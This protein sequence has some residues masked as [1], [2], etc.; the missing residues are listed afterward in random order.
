VDLSQKELQR[1][2]VIENAVQG[3]IR[4]GEAAELLELSPRQITR[5]KRDSLGG[6]A[7]WV[8]HGNR[9]KTPSNRLSETLRQQVVDL[10]AGRY[11][12]FNDTHLWEKLS[13]V[14]GL[15]LSRQSLQRI[16]RKAGRES[17]QKRRPPKYRSRRERRAQEG[18]MLQTDGS[19]HDW[20]EQRGPV[21]T[22]LGF[23]D[24][25][26][27]KVPNARF[28]LEGENTAGYL[29]LTRQVAE[30]KGVPLS[31]YRDQHGTFQRNDEHW[32]IQEQLAGS[33]AP[34]QLG[35]CWE[36]LGITS[37]PARSPQAKGR[38]ERLWRTFQD[39]LCSELRLAG[40]CTLEQA[41]A[42]LERFLP[43]FNLGFP[44]QPAQA[45]VAYRKLDRRLD[46]DYI[47]SFRYERVVN[48]DHTIV[49]GDGLRVQLPPLPGH[50]GY[51]G[52]K[53]EVC[54]LPNGDVKVY[55]DRRLLYAEAGGPDSPPVRSRDMRRV[56][57]PLKKKPLK[58]YAFAGRLAI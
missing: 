9:G 32:S 38:V 13:R 14:E 52:K 37:I 23:I 4:V 50:K 56:T 22:L 34:T 5:L 35:R 10:A 29:R 39:R 20:L 30:Q 26:T 57:G 51:A 17:P 12:G 45:G 36:E 7:E 31:I 49:V 27:G 54:Q 41:N 46:L 11:K 48:Q 53:A 21:L 40:A 25:A 16:L 33:Q 2:K 1:I 44:K 47:F 18:M 8:H 19:K 15:K 42:V 58:T 28:Q 6:D 3:R 43:E 55:L 24:D